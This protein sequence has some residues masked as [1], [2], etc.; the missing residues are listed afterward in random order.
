MSGA[1]YTILL[2]LW[3]LTLVFLILWLFSCCFCA[4]LCP[5]KLK[6]LFGFGLFLLFTASA[7]TTALTFH[8]LEQLGHAVGSAAVGTFHVAR[9]AGRAAVF[10]AKVV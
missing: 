4:C 3:S 2:V 9:E 8:K 1:L 6:Y 5:K 7:L 10:V